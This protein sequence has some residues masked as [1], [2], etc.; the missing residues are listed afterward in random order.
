MTAKASFH[1]DDNPCTVR[2]ATHTVALPPQN[3]GRGDGGS[4]KP[5]T[6]RQHCP[7]GGRGDCGVAILQDRSVSGPTRRPWIPEPNA[8]VVLH[9]CVK[10]AE[11]P[12]KNKDG[13][14]SV[15]AVQQRRHRRSFLLWIRM[16]LTTIVQGSN[17]TIDKKKNP[18]PN[19]VFILLHPGLAADVSD[20][21]RGHWSIVRPRGRGV[22]VKVLR[23][24]PE[25]GGADLN[26]PRG[27]KADLHR[28]MYSMYREKKKKTPPS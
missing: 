2:S 13:N 21:L 17:T 4:V 23:L 9:V 22:N 15:P 27:G 7:L 24:N 19:L 26:L 5:S 18:A 14:D 3:A 10:G 11:T 25:V 8:T 12:P 28:V 6:A 16:I 20:R 1:N